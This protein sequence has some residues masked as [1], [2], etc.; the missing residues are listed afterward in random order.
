MKLTFNVAACEMSPAIRTKI[1]V[2]DLPHA[3]ETWNELV[4]MYQFGA[5]DMR[6]RCG[7]VMVGKKLVAR[8]HYNGRVEEKS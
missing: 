3:Q 6:G 4:D 8:I 2:R 7:D 5:S 1:A